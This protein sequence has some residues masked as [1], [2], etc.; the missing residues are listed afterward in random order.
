MFPPMRRL[1]SCAKPIRDDVTIVGSYVGPSDHATTVS[2]P[3]TIVSFIQQLTARGARPI[4]VAFGN[5][6]FLQQIPWVPEYVVALGGL[7]VSQQAAARALTGAIFTTGRLPI[8]IP[9]Y[10]ALGD[11]MTPPTICLW[12]PSEAHVCMFRNSL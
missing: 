12:S 4:V 2:A 6:Y 10:A 8:A 5:P 1:A 9:P 7:P 3:D 11:G